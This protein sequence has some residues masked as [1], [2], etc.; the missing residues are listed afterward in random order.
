VIDGDARRLRVAAIAIRLPVAAAHG[1][2]DVGAYLG[3]AST[4]AV[5]AVARTNPED[6][7]AILIVWA[8]EVARAGAKANPELCFLLRKR[9]IAACR[10]LDLRAAAKGR[11]PER[12]QPR[13]V[14]YETHD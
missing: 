12:E 1:I 4:D 11:R 9:L 7:A 6:S 14:S 2:E 5:E 10:R 13:N 3:C 8:I